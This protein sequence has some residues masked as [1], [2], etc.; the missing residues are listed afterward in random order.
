M[1]ANLNG[2][3]DRWTLDGVTVSR[4]SISDQPLQIRNGVVQ[5]SAPFALDTSIATPNSLPLF[6]DLA[7]SGTRET[8]EVALATQPASAPPDPAI[9]DAGGRVVYDDLMTVLPDV[10][11]TTPEE[12]AEDDTSTALEVADYVVQE[13]TTPATDSRPTPSSAEALEDDAAANRNEP[14][15][16]DAESPV[17]SGM[18]ASPQIS[19]PAALG[20][21]GEVNDEPAEVAT[22]AAPTVVKPTP[23]APSAAPAPA[24]P[25][26]IV[27]PEISIVDRVLRNAEAELTT[28]LQTG[29]GTSE[30]QTP[31]AATAGPEA[32]S[33][34]QAA[35]SGRDKESGHDQSSVQEEVLSGEAAVQAP[36]ED[37]SQGGLNDAEADAD[38]DA[39][40]FAGALAPAISLRPSPRP[41]PEPE[42]NAPPEDEPATLIADAEPGRTTAQPT[43]PES[44]RA[45]GLL[46][47]L[48]NIVAPNTP[49][50]QDPDTQDDV[51]PQEDE[52]DKIAMRDVPLKLR[53]TFRI[54]ELRWAIVENTRG[55]MSRLTIGDTINGFVII[56]IGSD[57]VTL[58]DGVAPITLPLM[59]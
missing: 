22:Q 37:V 6:R 44:R 24:P 58:S 1:P 14:A 32:A 53:G 50:R 17:P 30:I 4:W 2:P 18:F 20:T 26:Y 9:S 11:Q 52:P 16:T 56:D 19:A 25:P 38:A 31:P 12:D 33:D 54:K 27:S 47:L 55:I 59:P 23:L 35:A 46:S 8:S 48:G 21:D 29:R 36:L 51:A 15:H 7:P 28:L 57:Y 3:N 13:S 41:R 45:E 42:R 43:A 10:G 39:E 49:E 40:V 5:L 34:V